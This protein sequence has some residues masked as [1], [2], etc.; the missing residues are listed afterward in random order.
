MPKISIL[1]YHC[2]AELA[3]YSSYFESFG[4]LLV[5]RC[6]FLA[7][8]SVTGQLLAQLGARLQTILPKVHFKE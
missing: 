3:Q 1:T 7:A 2:V 8:E 4:Y 5:I 6:S